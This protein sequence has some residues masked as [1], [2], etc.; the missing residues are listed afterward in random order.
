VHF[1][2]SRHRFILTT[3]FATVAGALPATRA[4]AQTAESTPGAT[5][6]PQFVL[7]PIGE[8]EHG[9]PELELQPGA[10]A[11][12]RVAVTISGSVPV[13]LTLYRADVIPVVNGGFAAA[14]LDA[15][16]SGPT[17]WL[18]IEPTP[19]SGQPGDTIEQTV[20]IAVPGDATPGQYVTSLV[21][22][23]T[24][25]AISGTTMFNQVLRN[26]LPVVITVPG[27]IA[28]AMEVDEPAI[29]TQAGARFIQIP[30]ANTG[31]VLI[32]P[33]GT[34]IMTTPGGE[35]VLNAPVTMKSVYRGLT[36]ELRVA[37]P[38]QLPPGAYHVS[39]ELTEPTHGLR[40]T[41]DD[42]P[43]T[44]APPEAAGTPEAATLVVDPVTV[45]PSGEP[46]Q[47]AEV[48]ATIVNNGPAIPTARVSLVALRDGAE[49][50]TYDLATNQALPQ[51]ASTISQR[52]FPA[53]GWTEGTWTF[54][55]V[56][57]A[58]DGDTET[59]LAEVVAANGITVP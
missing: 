30:V 23:T 26:A 16:P 59:V 41:M 47:F 21:V 31:N 4:F 9:F 8:T 12:L 3:A 55:V 11:E 20:P 50:E 5:E 27:P 48:S 10:T 34:V 1:R 33:E 37:I 39:Y 52:Y 18:D 28:P 25:L 24:P 49:V 43:V 38:D 15:T 29:V 54:R 42:V 40:A 44:L 35:Q 13:D 6:A 14:E 53:G 46:I 45:T 2:L 19:L 58:L 22:Q 56:V 32:R 7:H 17:L 51:G 36:T 57:T